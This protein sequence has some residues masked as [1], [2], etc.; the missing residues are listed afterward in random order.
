MNLGPLLSGR[1]STTSNIVG[2]MTVRRREVLLY[3]QLPTIICYTIYLSVPPISNKNLCHTSLLYTFFL[4]IMASFIILRSLSSVK[5]RIMD[6][7]SANSAA[8][9]RT[10]DASVAVKEGRL[11]IKTQHLVLDIFPK[12]TLSMY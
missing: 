10:R 6:F 12:S 8:A 2:P 4:V 9:R 11:Y 3:M 5:H 7:F 1:P